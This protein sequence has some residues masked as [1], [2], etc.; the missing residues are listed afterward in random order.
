MAYPNNDIRRVMKRTHTSF[1]R[2]HFGGAALH[3]IVVAIVVSLVAFSGDAHAAAPKRKGVDPSAYVNMEPMTISIIED[4]RVRGLMTLKIGLHIPDAKTRQRVQQRM[5]LLQDAM[6][7]TL[8]A[9]GVT[10][11][12]VDVAP[13]LDIIDHRLSKAI[14]EVV[15][16]D[17]TQILFDHILVRQTD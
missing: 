17:G 11:M 12:R 6:V 10:A 7:R 1:L 5:I 13:N 4:F 8:T 2:F 15:G 3:A 9:Y 16:A 14:D